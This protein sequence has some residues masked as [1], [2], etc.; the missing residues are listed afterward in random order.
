MSTNRITLEVTERLADQLGSRN[1][2]RLRKQGLVPGVL[3]GKG[4]ARPFAV[5]ERDLRNALTGPSGLH[6]IVDVL[7]E[8]TKTPHHA[9]VKEFQRHPV[10]GTVTHIDFHEVP[11]DQPIQAT[12]QIELAGEAPGSRQGGVVQPVTRELHIEALPTAIPDH[13]TVDIGSLELGDTLRLE[14]IPAIEGVTFLDDPQTALALCESPREMELEEVVEGEDE[15]AA[16]AD[17]EASAESG[18]DGDA[19]SSDDTPAE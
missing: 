13:V 6:A 8:G 18:D 4:Q 12:V 14:Q 15:E 16:D 11:L 9:V 2:R 1:V 7:I 17:A 5:G 3:Y 19:A 10:R